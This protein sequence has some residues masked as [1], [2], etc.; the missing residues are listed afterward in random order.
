MTD[1]TYTHTYTVV[2]DDDDLTLMDERFDL[3]GPWDMHATLDTV[4]AK[5]GQRVRL[6]VE[7]VEEVTP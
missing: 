1:T 3:W 5:P 6:T 7:I 4:G 2:T